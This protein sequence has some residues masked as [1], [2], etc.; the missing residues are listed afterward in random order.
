MSKLIKKLKTTPEGWFTNPKERLSYYLYFCGQNAIY[1]LVASFLTTYLM[2][3]IGGLTKAASIMLIVKIWDAVNDAIFGV[4]FDKIKFKSGKKFVPWLK[5]SLIFIPLTTIMMFAIPMG[6]SENAKL[7]W[8]AVSYILWDTAYTLCDVPIF[9]VI[10]SMS[11]NLDE[12]NSIIS[13][14]Q[15]WSGIGSGVALILGTILVSEYIKLNY[16]VVAIAC[17]VFALITMIPACFRLEERFGGERDEEFTLRK[18]FSYLGQNK[19]LL[20]YYL[21]YFFYSSANVSGSLNLF[22]SFYLFHNSQFSLVVQALSL[23]PSAIFAFLVPHLVRKFDKMKIFRLC[24]LA[25]VI[26]SVI[27]W[28]I[29]YDSML[30]FIIISVIRSVPMAILGVMLFMFTPDCAEYGKFTSGI[31]AKGITFAIQTFM[32]K[33][34]AAVSGALGMFILGLKS[35]GWVSVENAQN[36]ADLEGVSQTP[37]AKAVLWFVYVMVTAIGY[38]IAYIIWTRYNMTDK[39]VQIMADCNSGKITHEEA[40]EMLGDKYKKSKKKS[41]ETANKA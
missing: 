35:T 11:E 36:F 26:L 2:F 19:Y 20:I 9:G 1:N 28:L 32:V 31:E 39:E 18:M 41:K 22:V 4:L 7:A 17:S 27:M 10:T 21:G 40:E 23:V 25:T 34:T 5:I 13:Y 15:I 6:F 29:G 24:T 37:H 12:R 8:L 33:L 38:A 14:K 3:S 30:G 16:T